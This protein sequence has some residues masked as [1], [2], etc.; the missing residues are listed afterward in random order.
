[1]SFDR[2]KSIVPFNEEQ[3]LSD[4]DEI[5]KAAIQEIGK[6]ISSGPLIYIACDGSA[7][8]VDIED[9]YAC[10]LIVGNTRYVPK[11]EYLD[12]RLCIYWPQKYLLNDGLLTVMSNSTGKKMLQ[13]KLNPEFLDLLVPYS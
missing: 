8:V 6:I 3:I 12:G 1:M 9:V 2:R 11:M 10:I 13:M 4:C 5:S 7:V